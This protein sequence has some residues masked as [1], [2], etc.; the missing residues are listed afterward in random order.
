MIAF[1]AG[2]LPNLP[3]FLRTAAP[4]RFQ[5]IGDG[6]VAAY[7]YAWFIGLALALI[8]YAVLMWRTRRAL[9]S[10]GAADQAA[11]SAFSSA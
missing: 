7:A 3:G 4:E 1:A 5:W 11:S 6:W 9:E 8:V 2:V 10:G